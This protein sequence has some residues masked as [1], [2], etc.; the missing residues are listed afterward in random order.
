MVWHGRYE[1]GE[2]LVLPALDANALVVLA[3]EVGLA[4]RVAEA[5]VQ[6]VV[7]GEFCP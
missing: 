1:D 2:E 4:G 6:D 7:G 3:A 5:D